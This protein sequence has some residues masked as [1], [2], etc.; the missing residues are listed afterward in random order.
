MILIFDQQLRASIMSGWADQHALTLVFSALGYLDPFRGINS[1]RSGFVW[2][3]DILNSGYP[4]SVRYLLAGKVVQ[5]LGNEVVAHP[6]KSFPPDWVPPLLGF[7]SLSEKFYTKGS[8]PY[9]GLTALQILLCRQ[10]DADVD[11]GVTLLPIL[12]S[13]LVHDHPLQSRTLALGV[14]HRFMP[15]WFSQQMETV[16]NNNLDKLLR[17]VGDPFQ[18]PSLPLQHGRPGGA[19][20][21]DPMM[22][23]VVL[24]EFASSDLWRNHLNRSNFDSC[25]EVL[26]TEKGRGSA[27]RCMLDNTTYAWSAFLRT[28]AKITTAIRR[29]E[30]LQC[31]NTAEVVILWAWT[32]GVVNAADHDAWRSIGR[33]TLEFYQAHGTGRLTTL[34]RH[35]VGTNGTAEG[36]HLVFLLRGVGYEGY[37]CRVESVRHPV[38]VTKQVEKK[39]LIDLRVSQVCQLRRLHH[40]FGYDLATWEEAVAIEETDEEMDVLSGRTVMIMPVRSMDWACDYP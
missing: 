40:L 19:T 12:A 2:I 13:I 28:P 15:G 9:P 25:E 31:L 18:F 26:S 21:F 32:T 23:M 39:H 10:V 35:L 22:A 29:L 8:P 7:L 17:A 27:L 16:S 3:T 37:P 30:E 33:I 4:E 38:L 11:V 5:L 36:D 14:F 34:K 6:P 20:G 1:G 24:I